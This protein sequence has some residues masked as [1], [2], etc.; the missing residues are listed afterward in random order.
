MKQPTREDLE[1]M[2]LKVHDY[3]DNYADVDVVDG[4]EHNNAEASM[5]VALG[6]KF[7][8]MVEAIKANYHKRRRIFALPNHIVQRI[9]NSANNREVGG[10]Q[11]LC[12]HI[13]EH[14]VKDGET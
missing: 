6:D 10:W 11:N 1:N 3:L 7:V 2:I 13:M 12:A 4:R 5:Q 8:E 14:E 9:V